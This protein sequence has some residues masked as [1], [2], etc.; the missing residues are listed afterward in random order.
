MTLIELCIV[1]VVI[2]ILMV[3]GVASLLRARM[4]SNETAAIGGL[5]ATAT[6]QFAYSSGCGR[7]N[8]ATSYVILGTRP[9]ANSQGYLA[10][11]LGSAVNPSRNGYTFALALGADGAA[12]F[13]DCTGNPT[14]TAYYASARPNAPGQTGDRS[15]AINQLGA[16]YQSSTAIPPTEPFGPPAQLVR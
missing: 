5:R 7:G 4:A 10:E 9:T 11:D 6:A 15:F 14:Q 16:I 1:I 12:S 8:Y 2:G 13:N 3:I